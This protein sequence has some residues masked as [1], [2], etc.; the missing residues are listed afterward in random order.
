LSGSIL[1]LLPPP[2]PPPPPTPLSLAAFFPF[3]P[4][5]APCPVK[6]ISL[7]C[8][9]TDT[10]E[11]FPPPTLE[12]DMPLE[13]VDVLLSEPEDETRRRC[14]EGRTSFFCLDEAGRISSRSMG[15]PRETR[16]RR[17]MRERIQ[18]G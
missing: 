10:V 6:G 9:S 14:S 12:R 11:A 8:E 4:P 2:L 17:R 3:P 18:S 13:S 5:P 7:P 16:K 1:L 15:T